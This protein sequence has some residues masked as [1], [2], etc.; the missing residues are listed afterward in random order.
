VETKDRLS[1]A[2]DVIDILCAIGSLALLFWF[3]KKMGTP[4]VEGMV[5]RA[6]R[7]QAI[8]DEIRLF[9]RPLEEGE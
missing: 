2:K 5:S 3:M 8:E 7:Q 9:G 6:H 1:T 4:D